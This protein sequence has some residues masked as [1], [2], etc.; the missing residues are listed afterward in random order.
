[1][2][3][4]THF[5]PGFSWLLLSQI[6]W[7]PPLLFLC[8]TFIS[9]LLLGACGKK[10]VA[11]KSFELIVPSKGRT[12]FTRLA[13]ATT[14]ISFTNLLADEKAAEN[15]IRLNGSGLT[16]GDIDGDGLC[17]L[18][19]CRLDGPNVL[20]RNLGNWKFEDITTM[21]AVACADQFSQGTLFADVDGDGDLDLLVNSVGG[22]T[23]LF[24]NDGKGKFTEVT[25][26][27][28]IRK[29]AAT[30]M[31]MADIDGDGNLDLYVANYR[32]T[33][34]RSTGLS[35]LNVD[36]KRM[37]RLED[38]DGYEFTPD[39]RVL[40]YGEVDVLYVNDG[41]GH[42]R[43]VSFTDGTFLDEDGK[44][45]KK[46]P[47][48]WGLSVM[49]R[50]MNGD[51]APDIYVC[52]D[53]FTPDRIWINNGNGEFRALERLALRN[54]SSFSMG[55]DFAD[56]NR[57]GY[58]DFLVL[59]MLDRRHPRRMMQ[60]SG[61]EPSSIVI[62]KFDDRPQIDRNTV[63][64]NRGDGTYAEIAYLCGLEASGWSWCPVFLDVD[65]DGYEDIL[66][67]TGH[68]FDTQDLDAENRIQ[69]MG[70]GQKGMTY[71]KL[72]MF[73]GLQLPKIAFHNLGGLRFAEAGREW[74][75]DD[76]GISHGMCLADLDNDGD[77]DVVVNNLNGPAGIYRNESSAPRVA[78]RLKGLP[79]N[80][81]GIG[82]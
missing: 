2:R 19:F 17:D 9:Q 58:D 4:R 41:K 27:G 80:T 71:K 49:F 63:Q 74:G 51:G 33:T 37:F 79:S 12:G 6:V 25:T 81:R 76:I 68:M 54:M 82:A 70:P 34:F 21:P 8:T 47:R 3:T 7:S 67:T 13:T 46:P 28:L 50:D 66:I 30:S 65:L 62:G 35:V 61:M 11:T 60:I 1:M 31:A 5:V 39:G 20:Y 45:L 16:A 43:A 57:D 26:S 18:Y 56:I 55:I 53:F 52:N 32:T 48:D 38:R 69:A 59:D 75:F 24:L 10:G 22:G 64:L 77:L 29:F 14:G 23:R 44:P 40:E 78:V 73:P 15:Q 42:F 36:G 72:L